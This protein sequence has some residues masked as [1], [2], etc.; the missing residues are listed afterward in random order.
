MIDLSIIENRNKDYLKNT[1]W[2]VSQNINEMI[3]NDL[4]KQKHDK[5]LEIGAGL[6]PFKLSTHFIDIVKYNENYTIVDIDFE[7]LPFENNTFDYV[8]S[9]H[10]MED[11]YNPY[12]AIKE[13][14]R[15]SKKGYIETPSPLVETFKNV[16]SLSFV[17]RKIS[18]SGYIHHRFILYTDIE[19][20]TLYILPKYPIIEFFAYSDENTYNK[21]KKMLESSELYWNNYYFWDELSPPKVVLYRHGANFSVN[22]NYFNLL[23][24]AINKSI[25]NTTK[26]ENHRLTM[27]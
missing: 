22:T 3:Y 25:E 24:I 17:Q 14:F 20:N 23:D 16:D 13:M 2:Y 8:Y 1:H 26:L 15:V 10:T 18:Y 11:I 5:V 21:L 27:L 4:I 7:S 6:T 19:T 12:F 9:R